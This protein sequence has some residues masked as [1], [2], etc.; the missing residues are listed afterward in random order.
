MQA[1]VINIESRRHQRQATTTPATVQIGLYGILDVTLRDCSESGVFVEV[2]CGYLDGEVLSDPEDL[3]AKLECGDALELL[4][5][6]AKLP[7]TL[8]WKG[9]HKGHGVNGF[10]AELTQLNRLVA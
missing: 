10:G 7:M 5:N 6:G 2:H 1:Q 9:H 8:R 3:L 4:V